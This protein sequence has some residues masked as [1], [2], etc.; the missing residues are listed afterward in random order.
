MISGGWAVEL[1]VIFVGTGLYSLWHWSSVA[2]AR[3]AAQRRPEWLTGLSHLVMSAAMIV[4]VWWP[5]GL[6]GTVV[7]VVVFAAFAVA[8]VQAGV[9]ASDAAGRIGA[10]GHTIMNA[11][12][13]WMLATMPLL[14]AGMTLTGN[15]GG[16]HA[17][18]GSVASADPA[19]PAH[20]AAP[21]WA[22]AVNWVW[23]ALLVAAAGWWIVRLIRGRRKPGGA[24]C[25][26][27]MA[28]A[29][30]LMLAVMG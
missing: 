22:V 5:A 21:V 24:W 26:S 11:A 25:H 13:A 4:M 6:V 20:G 17:H 10:V 28:V 23:I 1:T 19:A 8:F 7:Q 2:V 3:R 12:M 16:G 27:V 15:S 9:R 18:H 30:A 29:M 14:M